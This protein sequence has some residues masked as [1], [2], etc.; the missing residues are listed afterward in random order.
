MH[1]FLF[2]LFSRLSLLFC[3]FVSSHHYYTAFC[4]SKL[5]F[6]LYK[7]PLNIRHSSTL[8]YI[9]TKYIPAL[10]LRFS[11]LPRR[12]VSSQPHSGCLSLMSPPGSTAKFQARSGTKSGSAV[13]MRR[14]HRALC[15]GTK[16]FISWDGTECCP[17]TQGKIKPMG[18]NHMTGQDA[19]RHPSSHS[20][21]RTEDQNQEGPRD[22]MDIS[23]ILS[24]TGLFL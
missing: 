10:W 11:G 13:W 4:F 18:K 24:P 2:C 17:N 9:V 5:V 19:P 20:Q 15:L 16:Q 12:R 3:Q 21:R 6:V 1:I 22:S 7:L 8:A 23:E 14:A